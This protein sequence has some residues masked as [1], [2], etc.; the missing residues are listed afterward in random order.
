MATTF[1]RFER[2]PLTITREIICLDR[3][4][5]RIDLFE[6]NQQSSA[7][8]LEPKDIFQ[9][10]PETL[11]EDLQFVSPSFDEWLLCQRAKLRARLENEIER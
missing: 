5:C 9:I 8:P 2:S 4:R 6:V 7:P 11:L 10:D 3:R 1:D